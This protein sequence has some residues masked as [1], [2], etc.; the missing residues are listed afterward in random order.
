MRT[1]GHTPASRVAHRAISVASLTE[2]PNQ[3]GWNQL[4]QTEGVSPS[5]S[6]SD[7]GKKSGKDRIRRDFF[8]I[9]SRGDSTGRPINAS[10]ALGDPRGRGNTEVEMPTSI[11]PVLYISARPTGWPAW[12]SVSG[13]CPMGR[14]GPVGVFG[15]S[16]RQARGLQ[17]RRCDRGRRPA[18][19]IAP[20]LGYAVSRGRY[21]R[22]P[23]P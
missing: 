5:V 15:S 19:S 1:K 11:S 22:L 3:T 17:R 18:Q 10:S 23:R 4:S 20:R 12:T 8:R 21:G 6:K 13:C 16:A 2:R 9:L 14:R 7:S